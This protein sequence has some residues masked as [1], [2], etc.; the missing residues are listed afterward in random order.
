MGIRP[1]VL[2]VPSL[3][4]AVELPRRL[5]ARGPG[6]AGV[7]PFRVLDL[8]RA[9]AEPALLGRG[10]KAWD[11]GHDALLAARLLDEEPSPL[12]R[13]DV[14][15]APVAAALARTLSALRMAGVEAGS[16][17]QLAS[18]APEEDRR[19]LQDLAR[20]YRRFLAEVEGRFA[21]PVTLLQAAIERL[22]E[23][24]WLED[25]EVLIV[26]ELEPERRELE[27]VATLAR[28]RPVR[29]IAGERPP[30][31]QAA[32]FADWAAAH[33]VAEAAV[34]R[35]P[36]APLAA[37]PVPASLHRLRTRL[38]EPPE[39][40][41]VRD[42][43]VELVTA[44]GE[45]AEVRALVRRVLRE[46]AHGVP[47]EEMGLILPRPQE[48][49]TLVTDLL[50]RLAI[51][52]RLH[53]SLPLRCGRSARSLLLL[54]RCRGLA[55]AAVMEFLTF[56]PVPFARLL[57]EERAR[58]WLAQWDAI[59][60]EAGIVG[61]LE[62]WRVAL[63]SYAASE[64]A[65]AEAEPDA[66]RARRRLAAAEQAEALLQVVESLAETLAGLA[67]EAPW[68]E[69]SR[70]LGQVFDLWIG[71][72]R[73]RDRA[74][75]AE[76]LADLAGLASVSPRARW[77]EVEGVLETRFEW[78]R[79]PAE[80]LSSGGIHV[81][82][83]DAMAG[84]SFRVVAIPG[85]VEGGY[86]GVL[87]PD[88][89]LLDTEREALGPGPGRT[90]APA[91]PKARGQLSLFEDSARERVG[92]SSID[93]KAAMPTT[94]DRLRET[95][96]MFHRALRQATERLILSYPR[97]D[98]RTGRE[99]LPS[100]FFAA[101]ASALAGRPLSAAEMTAAV[102]E[103]DLAG[104]ASEEAVDASERDRAR[105]VRGGSEAVL[106][107]AAGSPFFKGSHLAARARWS[108]T[109]THFDG[110]VHGLP[111]EVA[112]RLDPLTS[113]R[114]VSASSLANYA[115]C[116]FLYL[117]KNVLGL[118]A[119]QEPVERLGLDPLEQ[120]LLF[121][122]VAEAYLRERRDAGALPVA[123]DEPA[124]Q[125]LLQLA[126]ERVDRLVAGTPPRHRLVWEMRWR[127]FED[128]LLRWLAREAL[129]AEKWTPAHFEVGFGS[130]RAGATSEPHSPDPLVIELGDGRMLR[131]SGKI[132]RI[133]TRPD[134]A[135]VLR[136][137][138]TGR[139]PRDDGG[140]FRGGREL[141]IPIYVLATR[142]LF[143]DR[144]VAEAFLDYVNG[145]RPVP[146]DPGSVAGEEFRRLLGDMTGAIADGCFVQ[147][148]ASC[149][150]CDFTATC[151]P[152]PLLELRQRFK[153]GDARVVRYLRLRDY[154]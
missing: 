111:A 28:L 80:P 99:R 106:A 141:Q 88:P 115:R 64:R 82:A 61:G 46:A 2:L 53:P 145:G 140:V 25:A 97:A 121:H 6:L 70:R 110:A 109:L 35:T 81:G 101:A 85:L 119:A 42:G 118:E 16:L 104:L 92:S 152:Q 83:L 22:G 57:G 40:D 86:P 96:R 66:E 45:A 32:S 3:A 153:R 75:V 107:I 112:R 91:K 142:M 65:G 126:R 71:P 138:K 49:A 74:A 154:R 19:R 133:D 59:S 12:V 14:A 20:L 89:F 90:G 52:H 7:Y 122:E 87:R 72:D 31:L 93:R 150:W 15:R 125:R 27:F 30:G 149:K 78:E 73:E 135:L 102:V 23:A 137:Y 76:M 54:F 24:R 128:L 44:A 108:P 13:P 132:D 10:L 67:G 94:Q 26:D 103:D 100:L 114:P 123:D 79:M 151:G 84:L 51:P 8:A 62:R 117:L 36:L 37:P 1:V 43:A 4:A 148:P 18:R 143:P 113:P 116:G 77:S 98:A 58:P 139:A 131:V 124:R 68:P 29:L 21:D 56:A 60:R 147:E 33:G 48:Y 39:G 120:G 95:R 47:F 105:V 130:A 129:T 11:G 17:D 144:P 9:V 69:W 34:E 127:A 5:A 136:D 41:A 38:F 146:F 63:E 50:E 55:R 134:G